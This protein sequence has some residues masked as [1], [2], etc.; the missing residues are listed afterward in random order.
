MLKLEFE[1]LAGYEVSDDDYNKIIEPMYMATDLTKEEFVKV[2]DKK[3]FSLKTKEQLLIKMR[4]IARRIKANCEYYTDYE[5]INELN[6][7]A[8]EYKERVLAYGYII[9]TKYTLEYLG[10]CR[11][12]SYPAEIDYY[13]NE[14]HSIVRIQLV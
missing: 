13:D 6:A 1:K 11:G 3:R 4:R 14:Y 5:A 12:C 7:L 10:E 2:I 9:N 8:E